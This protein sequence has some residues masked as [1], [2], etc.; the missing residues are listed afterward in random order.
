MS[1]W[2]AEMQ[3]N[4]NL[5]S[6]HIMVT[7]SATTK[8]N[9]LY[10]QETGYL[11][12]SKETVRREHLDSYLLLC[13]I[14]GKGQLIYDGSTYQL[15][16][17]SIF[18]ID[19]KKTFQYHVLNEKGWTVVYLYFNGRQAQIYYN[20]STK[21]K[22]PVFKANNKDMIT[23]RF[24]QIIDLHQKK[25]KYAELLTSM[26]IT[27][28]L[29]ELCIFGEE[30]VVF[31]VDFPYYIKQVFHHLNHY[32][33]EKISL[34]MLSELYSVNK[35]HLERTFKRC[36]GVTLAEYLITTRI[37]KAKELLHFSEKSIEE[38]A[39]MLGFYSAGHFIKQFNR[40]EHIT[41][42]AYK[43]QCTK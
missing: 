2:I 6:I 24:W 37:N 43:K 7:P 23:S 42:L 26:H 14:N 22:T 35:Y 36:S 40:R 21:H 31:E 17:C 34:D 33:E 32:Y 15:K 28:I 20:I 13:V 3:K 9:F 12:R 11:E 18:F 30:N 16:E 27:R 41:P 25:N 19:C 29:T 38:I 39:A 4:L 1:E 5:N 8:K 10:A